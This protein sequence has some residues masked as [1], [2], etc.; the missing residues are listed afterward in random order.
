VQEFYDTYP[1]V[2]HRFYEGPDSYYQKFDF[3]DLSKFRE[4]F[5]IYIKNAHDAGVLVADNL[6]VRGKPWE[7]ISDSRNIEYVFL[8]GKKLD[9]TALLNSWK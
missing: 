4:N 6:L 8:K 7:N 3:G 2:R 5:L 1:Q 9:R